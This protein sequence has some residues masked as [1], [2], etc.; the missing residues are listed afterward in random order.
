MYEGGA[1]VGT[2]VCARGERRGA[3]QGRARGR[4]RV[5]RVR[6][7]VSIASIFSQYFVLGGKTLGH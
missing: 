6:W 7:L 5:E 1:Y 3:N 4:T 2:N